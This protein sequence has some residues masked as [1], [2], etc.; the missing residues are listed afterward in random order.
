MPFAPGELRRIAEEERRRGRAHRR[1]RWARRRRA[2]LWV[3]GS[4]LLFS[5]LV[6]GARVAG[7]PAW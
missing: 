2:A 1:L 7:L 6:L 4:A 5:L 3:L